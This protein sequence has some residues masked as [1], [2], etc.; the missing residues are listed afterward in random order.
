MAFT[1]CQQIKQRGENNMNLR[2]IIDMYKISKKEPYDSSLLFDNLF[3][4][5]YKNAVDLDSHNK[6]FDRAL[7]IFK[8]V[9]SGKEAIFVS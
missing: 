5:Y 8:A 6:S 9:L 2:E 1:N 4:Y 3:N 7:M